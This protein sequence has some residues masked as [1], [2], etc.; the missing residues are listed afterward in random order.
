MTPE[1]RDLLAER[2][3]RV[4]EVLDIATK[5]AQWFLG[6]LKLLLL[7]VI[8]VAVLVGT[9]FY[10]WFTGGTVTGD[11]VLNAVLALSTLVLFCMCPWY[12]VVGGVLFWGTFGFWLDAHPDQT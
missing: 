11:M 9:P 5:P 2:Q 1:D 3:S 10:Y 6:G 12:V 8:I 4:Y 7:G